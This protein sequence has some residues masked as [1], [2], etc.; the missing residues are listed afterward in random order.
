MDYRQTDIE[1]ALAHLAQ[2]FPDQ[3]VN[4]NKSV[5]GTVDFPMAIS[6]VEYARTGM[7]QSKFNHV[8]YDS[9]KFENVALTGSQINSTKFL[10]TQLNGNSFACC[11]FFDVEIDG[12][13]CTPFIANNFSLSNFEQCRF[14]NL[15]LVSS[16]M[17]GSMF[18]NCCFENVSFQSST[19]E[20]TSFVN[21]SMAACDL[22]GVNVEFTRFAKGKFNAVCFP[23][24]QFPYII[25]A[26]DYLNSE[27]PALILRAGEK[28]VS[29]SE[30]REQIDNLILYF[31]DK[32]EYFPICNLCITKNALHDAKQ[33]LVDGITIALQHRDFRMIRYFCQ[34]ALH[35][36]MMDE[37]TRQRIM[38]SVD[39]FLQSKEIA[40]IPD[41]QLNYY[42]THIGNIRTL[43]QSGG[44]DS[45]TLNFTIETDV[46][47]ND[48]EG[49]QYINALLGDLN[50]T[51]AQADGQNGF[52]VMV[53]NYC[54]YE[55]VINVL[56]GVGSAASIISLVWAAIDAVK[57]H[58]TE[59]K[60]TAIEREDYY[61]CVDMRVDNLCKEL[62]RLQQE[63][64]KRRFSKHI[65]EVTQQLKT[66]LE[67]LYSKDIMLFKV[68]NDKDS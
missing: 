28:Q 25:G 14:S 17:L 59:K 68:T 51:L 58:H 4:S 29:P 44:A 10:Q 60:Y 20:G 63:C 45:I 54:P 31:M 16:G 35:H 42:M 21:C 43:L 39:G 41:T 34:L 1:R 13:T 57:K 5:C 3:K 7:K 33:Y 47:R 40:E 32:H 18:H 48:L 49:V 26:A 36:N 65:K 56:S 27:P 67:E 6:G 62:L 30:Y 46:L 11:E 38:Q 9:C 12:R 50:E 61:R 55:I 22:S 37:F 8:V 53:T 19:L 23:F 15:Q 24:Y 2:Y 52:Q 66:D 64:S